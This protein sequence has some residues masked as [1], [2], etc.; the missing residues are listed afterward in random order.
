MLQRRQQV[1]VDR[2]LR[3]PR[4][5]PFAIILLKAQALLRRVGQLMETVGQ[6]YAAVVNLKALRDAVVLGTD[7]RQRCLAGREW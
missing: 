7:L 3:Q 2:L 1:F 5:R 6:L 4:R